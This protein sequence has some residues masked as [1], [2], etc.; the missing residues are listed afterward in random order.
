MNDVELH[1]KAEQIVRESNISYWDAL[2]VVSL[3]NSPEFGDASSLDSFAQMSDAQ[4]DTRAK[5]YALKN[6]VSYVE[7]LREVGVLVGSGSSEFFERAE[8]DSRIAEV[9]VHDDAPA[10]AK[11]AGNWIEIFKAG[12]HINDE[13]KLCS[14]SQT[15]IENIALHYRP[16]VREAPIVIGHPVHDG[17]AMGWVDQMKA[18][19]DGK[20]LMKARQVD[21]KFAE[22]VKLGRYKKRSIALYS[23]THPN[24]PM[25]GMWYLRHVGFL[26]AA[27]PGV[28]GLRDINL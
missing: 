2:N 5:V 3:S 1:E 18:S 15:D 25:P 11:I 26:G 9:T 8:S 24:N 12:Q 6:G 22:A 19:P 7:A 28:S 14:F 16:S 10:N 23:P 4:L 21:A 13:G 17:P 20:L 27:Q